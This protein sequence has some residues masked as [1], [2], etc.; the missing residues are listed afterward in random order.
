MAI[1]KKKNGY[2]RR[3]YCLSCYFK[4]SNL[5]QFFKPYMKFITILL[6]IV[7]STAMPLQVGA[8][9]ASP[10]QI[11]P[12]AV[13]IQNIASSNADALWRPTPIQLNRIESTTKTYFAARDSNKFEDAYSQL[14]SRQKQF[15][16][17]PAYKKVLE[18]FNS[19][20][21]QTKG[22]ELR[23][24]TWYKDTAQSDPGLYVAVDFASAFENLAL[25]CGYVVWQ[26]QQ[27]G[28]YLL[29][30]EEVNVIDNTTMAKLKPGDLEKVY[31]QYRCK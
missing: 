14:S 17:F 13:P 23:V 19:N 26:E 30:R 8:Q 18:E 1:F 3:I 10:L 12:S 6:T 11:N 21:G 7:F 28:S 4:Y 15:L 22:R 16:T 29:V 27:D 9:G 20:A 25:H 2:S 31:A 24:I 5:I